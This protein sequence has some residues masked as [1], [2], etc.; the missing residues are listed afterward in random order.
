MQFLQ[1]RSKLT[2]A[3]VVAVL[4]SAVTF[5]ATIYDS[6]ILALNANDPTQL[7][8]ISRNGVPS[9]WSTPKA[10][11][12]IINP[13]TVYT[14]N[15]Y[16]VSDT[17]FKYVQITF[18][19]PSLNT[20]ASAYLGTYDPRNLALNYLG[21]AGYSGNSF[22][23]DPLVFQVVDPL[24][25]DLQIVVNTSSPA[26]IGAPFHIIVE[27]FTDTNFDDTITPEPAT[28]ALSLA[29]VL[30]VGVAL[31]MRRRSSRADA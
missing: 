30:M 21:D 29:G 9:D 13:T 24:S 4:G 16:A 22:G 7:G 17:N 26:G 12:G 19:S 25:S 6:G 11:P 31:F 27:G 10:F 18:D 8:R 3:L 15:T 1:F 28:A 23:T 5:G 20:F 2:K 14:F